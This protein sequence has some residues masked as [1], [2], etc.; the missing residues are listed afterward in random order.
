MNG[1][2][3]YGQ[4]CDAADVRN[5]RRAIADEK[6]ASPTKASTAAALT[7]QQEQQQKH[8]RSLDQKQ[9]AW[10]QAEHDQDFSRQETLAR[11][12][13]LRDDMRRQ[14]QNAWLGKHAKQR[15][16]EF[17]ADQKRMLRQWFNALDADGSG[18]ISVEVRMAAQHLGG[19]S[20]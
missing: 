11:Q 17:S 14:E 12:L 6:L 2:R 13:Q 1:A 8:R 19:S 15:R 18:K 20:V 10:W 7:V 4:L 9:R 3:G 5:A 16:F